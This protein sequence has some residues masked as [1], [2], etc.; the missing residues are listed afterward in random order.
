MAVAPSAGNSMK[1]LTTF[2]NVQ[3]LLRRGFR[4]GLKEQCVSF[5]DLLTYSLVFQTLER[6]LHQ[7]SA[8]LPVRWEGKI[9][10]QDDVIGL[11]IFQAFVNR[12]DIGWNQAVQGHFN[13][14]WGI[15][16]SL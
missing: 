9:P 4:N 8:D 13:R 1:I 11:A 16:N 12:K 14:Q 15:A 3:T 5:H 10:Q 6:G 7:W 2:F